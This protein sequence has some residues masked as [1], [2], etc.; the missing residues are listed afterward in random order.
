VVGFVF[1][2][3]FALIPALIAIGLAEAFGIRALTYYAA[4]G[5]AAG[6]L[7]IAGLGGFDPTRL[8]TDSFA[9]RELELMIGAGII[10]GLVYWLIAG[11]TAGNGRP[12][13]PPTMPGASSAGVSSAAPSDGAPP[14]T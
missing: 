14:P 7:V 3:G 12:P 11:R 1:V 9:R 2:S 5:A 13:P 10:G 6:A 4:A 8:P